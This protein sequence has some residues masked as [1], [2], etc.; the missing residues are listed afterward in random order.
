MRRRPPRSTRLTHSFPTRRSSDLGTD[1]AGNPVV[2]IDPASGDLVLVSCGNDG[3]ASESEVMTGL[4]TRQVYVQRSTDSGATWTT[5][6]DITAQA[7]ASW[8]RWYATGPG[9]GVAVPGGTHTARPVPPPTH[10]HNGP[11]PGRE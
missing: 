10:S 7:K 9:R 8:M 4:A 6:V 1:T 11:T 2:V 3:S 5:P